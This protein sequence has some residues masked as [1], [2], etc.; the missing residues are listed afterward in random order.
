MND[1][2]ETIQGHIGR[3][4]N[5]SLNDDCQFGGHIDQNSLNEVVFGGK[6]IQQRL[7]GDTHLSSNLIQADRVKPPGTEENRGTFKNPFAGITTAIRGERTTSH[8]PFLPAPET[9]L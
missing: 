6:P 3:G 7:F 9:F 1:R 5:G 8:H 4:T 2:F